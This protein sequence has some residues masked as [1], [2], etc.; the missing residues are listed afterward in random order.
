MR[1]LQTGEITLFISMKGMGSTLKNLLY[2]GC[3]LLRAD[4]FDKK[5]VP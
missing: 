4:Q 3:L 2:I 1:D 5:G